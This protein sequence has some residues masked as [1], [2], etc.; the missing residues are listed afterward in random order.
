MLMAGGDHMR[1]TDFSQFGD[2][3]PAMGSFT[4][5]DFE[6]K[7]RMQQYYNRYFINKLLS[8]FYIKLKLIFI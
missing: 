4:W 6:D 2:L 8:M 1:T 5:N 7:G 3:F